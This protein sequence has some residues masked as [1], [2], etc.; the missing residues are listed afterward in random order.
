VAAQGGGHP[1]PDEGDYGTGLVF[2]SKDEK[3][4]EWCMP[5]FE[6]V[7]EE[8]GQVFLGWRELPVDRSVLGDIA[9]RS[10]PHMSQVFIGRSRGVN[11]G[12]DFER[13]LFIIR[14]RMEK[15]AAGSGHPG[16][17][18]YMPSL[19]SRTM[20]YK[21]LLQPQD[22]EPYYKDL[23]DP[24]MKTAWPSCTSATAP[25]P[26]PPGSWPSPSASSATTA[27]STPCAATSTG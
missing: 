22:F 14:K 20:I 5:R 10:E 24:D 26:S 11:A 15:A 13:V 19:S 6:E 27:R 9:S 18:F 12:R 7:T 25:T 16:D 21:G 2:F 3:D 17:I 1:L 8:E 23:L 4:R